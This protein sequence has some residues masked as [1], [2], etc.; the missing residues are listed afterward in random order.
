MRKKNVKDKLI[1][2]VDE[3]CKIPDKAGNG[4]IKLH[5]IADSNGTLVRYSMAYI[6]HR[7]CHTDNG[8]VICYDNDHGYHHRH[9]MGKV[10]P[11]K[12]VDYESIAEQFDREWRIFHEKAK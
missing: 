3:T 1:T 10:E 12:Y 8:R 7:V 4:I 9:F 11:V 5:V 6:N 2:I